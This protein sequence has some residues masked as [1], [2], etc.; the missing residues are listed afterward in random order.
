MLIIHL[1]ILLANAKFIDIPIN[2]VEID[3]NFDKHSRSD[4]HILI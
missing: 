3:R 1:L 2:R 4:E